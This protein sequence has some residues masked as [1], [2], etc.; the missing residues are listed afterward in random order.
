M[1][2]DQPFDLVNF[3]VENWPFINRW[4]SGR[5]HY[6]SPILGGERSNLVGFPCMKFGLENSNDPLSNAQEN[7]TSVLESCVFFVGIQSWLIQISFEKVFQMMLMVK[8]EKK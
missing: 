7:E 5:G 1:L 2:N 3:S 6:M 4:L 8:I